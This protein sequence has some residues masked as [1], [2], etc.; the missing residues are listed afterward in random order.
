MVP[1]TADEVLARHRALRRIVSEKLS[2]GLVPTALSLDN[3]DVAIDWETGE[4][5]CL[6]ARQ[7]PL[8]FY[9]VEFIALAETQHDTRV[10]RG[11]VAATADFHAALLQI[12]YLIGDARADGVGIGF[13][14][15]EI[16]ANP[17]VLAAGVVAEE[18]WS[19]VVDR[20]QNIDGAIVVEITECKASG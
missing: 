14:P 20:D 9:P 2:G 11:E 1:Y 8:H 7:R 17:M 6:S 18:K 16:Q 19:P 5:L 13:L 10:M 12:A 15:D 4:A 3:I